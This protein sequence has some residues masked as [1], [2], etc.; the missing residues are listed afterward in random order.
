MKRFLKRA[1]I[2][3]V[4]V[5]VLLAGFVFVRSELALRS[6]WMIAEAPLAVPS[7]ADAVARGEHLSITRG[8]S[9]CHKKDLGGGTVMD[10]PAIG[11]MAAPNLTRGRGSVTVDFK[12][13]DW[14]RAVRHGVKPD[15]HAM[16]FMPIRDYAGLAD[17]DMADLI[18]YARQ[19]PAV[20]RESVPSYVGPVGR[21]LFSFGIMTMLE[22]RAI[23]QHAAHPARMEVA[24]TAE[25]GRYLAQSCTGCH[26]E[27]LSGGPIPGVPP[28]FPT[29]LNVTPDAK[30]G[31]GGWTKADFYRVFREGKKPDGSKLDPFMPWQSLGHFSDTELDALWMYLRTVPARPAGQR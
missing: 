2:A 10:A 11:R 13:E 12:P 28:D 14:E 24:A 8:C 3:F 27:H 9:N 21:A 25:F 20:D 23:D 15:G 1:L 16:L 5:F 30:S 22:A 6:T 19:M 17:A 4:V 29:P 7:D 31:I 26:G 18:A